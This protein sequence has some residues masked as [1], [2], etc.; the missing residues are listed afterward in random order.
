VVATQ[1]KGGGCAG[2]VAEP[3]ESGLPTTHADPRCPC[4]LSIP[5]HSLKCP[6]AHDGAAVV[7]QQVGY[8]DFDMIWT[9][10]LS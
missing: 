1:G 2:V 10:S 8:V 7:H 3:N 5:L 6:L 4:P 9:V